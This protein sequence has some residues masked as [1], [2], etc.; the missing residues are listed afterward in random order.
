MTGVE[1]MIDLQRV[2]YSYPDGA[3]ALK[4]VS[5]RIGSG[6][7]I[8]LIG[9]NGSGKS[10][11]LKLIG[12]LIAADEGRYFFNG[13]EMTNKRL[14]DHRLAKAFHKEVGFVFQ[15]P[16][17][18]LFCSSVYEE[19]AFGPIQMGLKEEEVDK[20][21][22][23]TMNLLGIGGLSACVPYHL[24][25]GEKKRVAIA[26]AVALN[27]RLYLFDEPMN[28]LDPKT[29]RFLRQFMINLVKLG[30]TIVCST[31]DFAYVDGIFKRAAVFSDD[32]R[33]IRVD[34]YERVMADRDF[35][36]AHNII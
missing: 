13:T 35:L 23:D 28:N 20:R 33:L 11:L 15:N 24:S 2:S 4:D 8:A 21:V 10:T 31:H 5:L 29:K 27:P 18:Q 30:K 19:I 3:P 16:D 32:H 26:T 9:P 7:A 1:K 6:E 17:T 14:K 12:G 22:T 34:D 25:G 36:Q